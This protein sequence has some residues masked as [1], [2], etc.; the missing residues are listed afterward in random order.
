MLNQWRPTKKNVELMY[1]K[2]QLWLACLIKII[3]KILIEF[4]LY[5]AIYR[6]C[7]KFT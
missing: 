2:G 3:E 7:L 1:E 4:I 5:S 6:S